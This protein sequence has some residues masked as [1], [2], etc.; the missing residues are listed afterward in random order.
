MAKNSAIPYWALILRDCLKI[1]SNVHRDMCGNM[2]AFVWAKPML[3]CFDFQ[4]LQKNET[5]AIDLPRKRDNL[6][7]ILT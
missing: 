4:F 5:Q 3:S 1:C 6:G 2:G 7:F